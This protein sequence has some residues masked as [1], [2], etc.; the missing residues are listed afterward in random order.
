MSQFEACSKPAAF[1]L[2]ERSKL[3]VPYL[4][5]SSRTSAAVS[6]RS[7]ISP[8][9]R[10]LEAADLVITIGYNPVEYWP[11]IWNHE[12][13]RIIVHIDV[14]RA[15]IDK[16]YRPA[17]ELIGDIAATTM[18]LA[19]LIDKVVL[20]R[21]MLDLMTEIAE[22]RSLAAHKSETMGGVPIHPLRLVSE[23]QSLLTPDTTLCLDMGSFHLWFAHYL[24]SFRARQ[25]LISNGQQTLGVALPWAIAA[26]LVRP[27]EKVLSVSG[28]GGFLFSAMELETAV[29]L[30]SNLVHMVWIDGTYDMVAVQEKAKY[31]RASVRRLVLSIQCCMRGLLE[32]PG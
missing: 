16:D 3:P 26:T 1:R 12:K 11:S 20:D 18:A 21:S 9:D 6:A 29:R 31:D 27:A 15:Y 4:P 13:Q 25:L 28:D 24:H 14:Q 17:V 8:G 7:A 30:Q 10:I 19:R 32:Q 2:L 5:P 22:Q 23:M